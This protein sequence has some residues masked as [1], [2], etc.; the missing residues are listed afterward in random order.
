MEDQ[1]VSKT[2]NAP[3]TAANPGEAETTRSGSSI[4]KLEKGEKKRK[5]EKN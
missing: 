1:Q 5:I 2:A 4:L 3:S